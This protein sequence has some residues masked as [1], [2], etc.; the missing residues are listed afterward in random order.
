MTREDEF[1]TSYYNGDMKHFRYSLKKDGK[2]RA[3]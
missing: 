1:I 3:K 2:E